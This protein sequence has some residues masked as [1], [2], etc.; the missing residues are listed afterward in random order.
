MF[1]C[2]GYGSLVNAG[3]LTPGTRTVRVRVTGW[4]RAWR[5]SGPTAYGRRCTLTVYSDPDSAIEGVVIAQPMD[6]LRALD[7][8]EGQ[9]TRHALD[10]GALDWLDPR[11]DGWPAP[12]LY[13]GNAEHRRPGDAGHP[14]MLSYL[15]VVIAGFLKTF[16]ASGADR[17]L[18]TTDDWHVPVLN[19]RAAPR[20]PRAL[21]LNPGERQRVDRCL[22][23][24]GIVPVH[25]KER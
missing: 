5:H 20:Y 3:T 23:E 18:R 19:D 22:E 1:T 7:K 17:F 25:T 10:A 13:V 6:T 9:Y 8:R 21:S 11:P 15:D 14:I 16:G 24:L 4:R 12:F 2:F